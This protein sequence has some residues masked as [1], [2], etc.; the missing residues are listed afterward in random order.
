MFDFLKDLDNYET[1]KINRLEP[2]DNFGVGV[3][4]AWTS[5]EGYETAILNNNEAY[6]VERYKTKKEAEKGHKKWVIAS[7]TVKTITMLS[8]L[9]GLAPE[10]KVQL[11]RAIK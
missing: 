1:R 7:K 11:R 6:P 9:C 3:S 10:K 2:E 4:T 8:G 5:D